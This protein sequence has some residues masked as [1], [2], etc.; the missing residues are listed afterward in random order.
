M[1]FFVEF[2]NFSALRHPQFYRRN[3]P[4]FQFPC[5]SHRHLSRP[6]LAH[7]KS[8]AYL[9]KR[10][11]NGSKSIGLVPSIPRRLVLSNMV[12]DTYFVPVGHLRRLI[13][14]LVQRR[15]CRLLT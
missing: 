7:P 2:V 1:R 12:G 9:L 8:F 4:K 6:F 14:G 13:K 11:A 15:L 10:F 5:G 3:G